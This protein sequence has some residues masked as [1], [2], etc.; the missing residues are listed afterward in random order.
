LPSAGIFG[1]KEASGSLWI[2]WR[3]GGEKSEKVLPALNRK[4]GF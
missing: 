4:S 2:E 1:I 3:R